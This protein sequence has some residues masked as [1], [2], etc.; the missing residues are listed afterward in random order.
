MSTSK[1]PTKSP[2]QDNIEKARL[3]RGYGGVNGCD[4]ILFKGHSRGCKI[5]ECDKYAKGPRIRRGDYKWKG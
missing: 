4:Y 3:L 1:A 5:A 2:Y